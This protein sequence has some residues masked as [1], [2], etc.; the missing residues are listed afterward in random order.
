MQAMLFR[1]GQVCVLWSLH[2]H[3]VNS[4]MVVSLCTV[5]T[6]P[7]LA[8]TVAGTVIDIPEIGLTTE[9]AKATST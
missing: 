1:W 8:V 7:S 2:P 3:L 6:R 5:H 4:P 9:M